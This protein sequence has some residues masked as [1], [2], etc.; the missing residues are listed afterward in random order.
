MPVDVQ[1]GSLGG[2]RALCAEQ[3]GRFFAS[4]ANVGDSLLGIADSPAAML[5][6]RG[7]E[8]DALR[9]AIKAELLRRKAALPETDS[10][11]R[12]WRSLRSGI[13]DSLP[14]A[15]VL[16]LVERHRAYLRREA[17]RLV[18]RTGAELDVDLTAAERRAPV[19]TAIPAADYL[20]P[21]R[22]GASVS[23]KPGYW[24]YFV[25][26]YAELNVPGSAS[27]PETNLLFVALALPARI[28]FRRCAVGECGRL[29]FV[30]D[31]DH[32]S[33]SRACARAA[34]VDDSARRH[35]IREQT[36][37]RVQRHRA[38]KQIKLAREEK[39]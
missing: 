14:D 1:P 29:F 35:R 7:L 31:A 6:A 37:I 10:W 30:E 21:T 9:R 13:D 2:E 32:R 22:P 34:Y 17:D 28:L 27:H 36:R 33:C 20:R 11:V 15:A 4:L 12:T 39:P 3:W 26:K 38:L 24:A 5:K 19:S 25:T 16:K 8:G 18:D 23:L